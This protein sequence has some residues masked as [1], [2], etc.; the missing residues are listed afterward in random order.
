VRGGGKKEKKKAGEEEEGKNVRLLEG[1]RRRKALGEALI[2]GGEG[3]KGGKK[4]KKMGHRQP[5]SV[6]FLSLQTGESE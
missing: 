5:H 3:G 1:H 4:E 2:E 6:P